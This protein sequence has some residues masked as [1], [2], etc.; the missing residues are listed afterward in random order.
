MR[1]IVH[2]LGLWLCAAALV[3]PG[4][5]RAAD[6]GKEPPI[7]DT[8]ANGSQQISDALAIAAKEHKRVLLQFGANW[9]IWC[10]RLHHT[11]ETDP[12]V[13]EM[14]KSHY[15]V[16]LVDIDKGHNKDVDEK[17]GNP[18]RLGLPVLVV[19]DSDGKQ[20]TTEDSGKL[21]EGDHHSPGKILE[22]LKAESGS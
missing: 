13:A 1:T 16:V 20:L 15:V 10:H 3:L 17:Y 19:L 22:F 9:C 11:C 2:G 7:Y 5:G 8:S 4:A 6:A 18:T 21:E 14:L 12:A